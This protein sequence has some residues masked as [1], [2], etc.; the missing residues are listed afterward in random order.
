[1]QL[2]PGDRERVAQ[3]GEHA[4]GDDRRLAGVADVLQQH[5]ELVAAE[6][7]DGVAGTDRAVEPLGDGLQELVADGVSERVVD[8]L[9]AVE[10]EEEDGCAALR[11]AAARAAQRLLEPV[12]E[13]RAVR[14]AGQRVVQR[15]VAEALDR[16]AVVGRVAD[17]ALERVG[18][19]AVLREVIDG[20]DEPRL[21]DRLRPAGV[22][23]QDDLRARILLE[24]LPQHGIPAER[25]VHQHGVVRV[26]GSGGVSR[27]RGRDPV[28]LRPLLR[29][30]PSDQAAVGLVGRDEQ[31][32]E[33]RIS[34]RAGA[35]ST[36]VPKGE[37]C[38]IRPHGRM[39]DNGSAE[40]AARPVRLHRW[41]LTAVARPL[42][43]YSS[44]APPT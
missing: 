37:Q 30:Q 5:R 28:D 34:H 4:L 42:R 16:A 21:A 31:E 18:V 24:D 22:A 11:P 23:E 40:R 26:L 8:Q 13:Q 6:A 38:A 36:S 25:G 20:A 32:D 12:E 3:G 15:A 14:E 2:A 1:M 17:G 29:Q 33:G 9:E 19:E 10:V 27:L 35:E 7:G 43:R 44:L 39:F 41:P